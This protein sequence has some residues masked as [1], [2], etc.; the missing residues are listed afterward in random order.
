MS[1]IHSFSKN[2]YSQILL[3]LL[4]LA[5]TIGLLQRHLDKQQKNIT[6]IEDLKYLP[7]GT[8]L[9]GAC[10]SYDEVAADLLWIKILGYFGEHFEGDKNYEWFSHL[11][12]IITTLD[13]FFEIPYEFGG[14]IL[15]SE[16]ADVD[17]SIRFLEKGMKNVPESHPRYWYL[18]FFQA[19]NY[20]YYRDDYGRA[21]QYLEVAARSTKAPSYLPLLVSRL[22]ANANSPEIALIFLNEMINSVQDDHARQELERRRKEIIVLRDI[23]ILETARDSYFEKFQSY[24]SRLTDLVSS[25]FL[26]EIPQEPFG[27]TYIMSTVNKTITSSTTKVELP[28]FLPTERKLEVPIIQQLKNQNK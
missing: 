16:M 13:L 15:A 17:G 10:L 14:I 26:R 23:Q 28:L 20:M 19:F 22:Y 5:P 11:L 7:N 1:I 8:F 2:I 24:P 9:K 4:L 27:G 21:A 6:K 25:G 3:L 12:E 18:P